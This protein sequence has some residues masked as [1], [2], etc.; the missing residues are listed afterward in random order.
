MF[1]LFYPNNKKIALLFCTLCV[2]Y[3][4]SFVFSLGFMC[5]V[6]NKLRHVFSLFIFIILVFVT[7]LILISNFLSLSRQIIIIKNQ[8][9]ISI[10]CYGVVV[11]KCVHV[12][13]TFD[14]LVEGGTTTN[15]KVVNF[16]VQMK[17]SGLFES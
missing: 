14:Q 7:P 10:H 4:W 11:W 13:F 3:I 12:L 1:I 16:F 17:F 6:Y 8:S 5:H 15:I 2:N 9:W